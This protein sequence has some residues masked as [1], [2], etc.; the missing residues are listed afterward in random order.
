MWRERCSGNRWAVADLQVWGVCIYKVLNVNPLVAA[1]TRV[2]TRN[3]LVNR[4]H[5]HIYKVV[6]INRL[7]NGIDPLVNES[8][9]RCYKGNP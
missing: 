1:F 5:Q 7:V 8:F 2:F 3:H 9:T 6:C 4:L